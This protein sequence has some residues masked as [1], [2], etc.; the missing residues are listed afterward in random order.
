MGAG[1]A[2]LTSLVEVEPDYLK[3]DISLVRN[4]DRSLIK[5]SLLETLVDLSSK[6]GAKVIAEGIEME[7]ELATL[8]E[9]GVPLGQGRFLGPPVL[10]G[11][12]TTTS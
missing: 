2:S 12:E 3:F 9:M 11:S 8:R 1:Y 6:I 7:P 4:I 10:V 5:R